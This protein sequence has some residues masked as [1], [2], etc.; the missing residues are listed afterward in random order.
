MKPTVGILVR[1]SDDRE[2]ERK[3]VKRQEQDCR[4]PADRLGW[5]VGE[6]YT[7]NDISL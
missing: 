2:D 3:G 5:L 7:E 6:V 1:I 4:E